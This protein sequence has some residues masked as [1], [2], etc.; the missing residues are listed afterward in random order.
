MS[1]TRFRS[2]VNKKEDVEVEESETLHTQNIRKKSKK[3]S[4]ASTCDDIYGEIN[5]VSFK[6]SFSRL[7][8]NYCLDK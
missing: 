3:Q 7:Q 8:K 2:S 4:Q 5:I 6:K 1:S